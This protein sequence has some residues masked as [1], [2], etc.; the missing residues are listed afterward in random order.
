MPAIGKTTLAIEIA[1]RYKPD[2][3]DAQLY[4]DCFGYTAG[5][6]PL[7]S[8]KILIRLLYF[9]GIPASLIPNS[10]EEQVEKWQSL[11]SKQKMIVIFDNIN[12]KDQID[13]LL[14]N[15]NSNALV[16]I[17][18]RE[19]MLEFAEIESIRLDVLD[20]LSAVQL[21][22]YESGEQGEDTEKLY[23]DVVKR[24]E[25]LPYAIIVFGRQ[26]RN[27]KQPIEFIKRFLKDSKTRKK[28]LSCI[29]VI[30]KCFE[31][32]YIQLSKEEQNILKAMGISPCFDMM[33]S[34]CAAMINQDEETVAYLLDKLFIK[35]LVLETKDNRYR[36]HDLMREYAREKYNEESDI[37][38]ED[39]VRNLV[40]F[41]KVKL[42]YANRV[43]YPNDIVT[44]SAI[45]ISINENENW[46]K[47]L[48]EE[49]INLEACLDY[50][51]DTNQRNEF[52][53]FSHLLS[54]FFRDNML[55]E[56]VMK[57]ATQAVDYSK[58][59]T[60]SLVQASALLDLALV[61]ED[62]GSFNK[63]IDLFHQAEAL[64]SI[65]EYSNELAYIYANEGFSLER[66]GD[67]PQAHIILNKA[68]KLYTNNNN[69]YGKGFAQNAI[70]AV[71]WRE[72]KY[73]EAEEI[74]IDTLKIR[75]RIGDR[76]GESATKNNLGFTYLKLNNKTEAKRLFN[77][78]LEISR[79]YQ[80]SHGESVT[81]N[82][83]GYYYIEDKNYNEAKSYAIEAR[84]KAEKVGNKYQIARS[85]DVEGRAELSLDNKPA[86]KSSLS[87]AVCY[88]HELNVPEY[89][90]TL[91]LLN[92]I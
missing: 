62:I 75:T 1:N 77:E 19:Q 24:L 79:D 71:Y 3:P 84:K 13:Q 65:E 59:S 74:F 40:Q 50:L 30:F 72:E 35:G 5:K 2:Y 11:L 68:S 23:S 86:A 55:G 66:L 33:P 6:E 52:V 48:E 25:Y 15:G 92:S 89:Y 20:E 67:Y 37:P 4:V 78:S 80:D 46:I 69:D 47:W 81:L 17:T 73:N 36:L 8:Q 91:D 42:S 90:E 41:Y 54:H 29:E 39:T 31:T 28:N 64:L 60:N 43:L 58:E 88:F 87:I 53:C 9:L 34:T 44:Y 14:P 16:I 76:L 22:I 38:V 7:D 10:Y 18:S 12:S 51:L 26:L 32:S 21:L 45:P 83:F 56:V 63:A 57:I 82:N 27:R 70:G 49:S 85:Y 61:N